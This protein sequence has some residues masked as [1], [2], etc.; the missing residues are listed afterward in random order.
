MNEIEVKL[1]IPPSLIRDPIDNP[2]YDYFLPLITHT[3]IVNQTDSYRETT[4]PNKL[5]RFRAHEQDGDII[6]SMKTHQPDA[7]G[8]MIRCEKER[9]VASGYTKENIHKATREIG[10]YLPEYA[11]SSVRRTLMLIEDGPNMAEVTIDLGK[12]VSGVR[13]AAISEIELELKQGSLDWL[14]DTA[15]GLKSHIYALTGY[16]M[17]PSFSKGHL[18]TIAHEV[19]RAHQNRRQAPSP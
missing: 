11:H 18:A 13:E 5:L 2:V 4:D 19:S 6:W 10:S 1:T 12:A 7:T 17:K 3:R 14:K 15:H 16:K 8:L 9:V